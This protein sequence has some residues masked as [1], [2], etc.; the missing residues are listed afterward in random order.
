MYASNI[1]SPTVVEPQSS[2]SSSHPDWEQK[3]VGIVV[4]ICS[5]LHEHLVTVATFNSHPPSSPI[6][7]LFGRQRGVKNL[8]VV[9]YCHRATPP[10]LSK[11]SIHSGHEYC[12]SRGKEG[13]EINDFWPISSEPATRPESRQ[14]ATV[15]SRSRHIFI[16]IPL[17][18]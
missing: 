7:N 14:E 16:N 2:F 4:A 3:H 18:L 12:V 13:D 17:G 8:G 11:C 6:N 1:L 15:I 9:T 10:P 5:A